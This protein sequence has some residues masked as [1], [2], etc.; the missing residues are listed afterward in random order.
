MA[1]FPGPGSFH[2]HQ[3]SRIAIFDR[4]KTDGWMDD[5]TLAASRCTTHLIFMRHTAFGADLKGMVDSKMAFSRAPGFYT[6]IITMEFD[7]SKMD[8]IRC[9]C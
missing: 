1:F 8:G 7:G 4:S 5:E 6:I 3:S 9:G 2:D